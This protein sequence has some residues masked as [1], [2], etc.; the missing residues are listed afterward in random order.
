MS[1]AVKARAGDMCGDSRIAALLFS[2]GAEISMPS[3]QQLDNLHAVVP[4]AQV[5]ATRY[6]VPASVTLAQWIV[7]SSWGMS[8]L[9]KNANNYFGIKRNLASAE[10]YVEMPTAEYVSGQRVM[11]EAQFAKYPAPLQSFTAHAMLLSLAR[12]YQPA[13]KV[14]DQPLLFAQQLQACGYSTSPTYGAMLQGFIREY[15]LTQYDIQ[16]PAKAAAQ[17]AA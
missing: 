13:M 3:Q 17:E 14:A 11:I 6:G 2:L 7:E 9:A 1:L 15:N 12:R 5:C 8:Q 10:Q 4:A 16:P